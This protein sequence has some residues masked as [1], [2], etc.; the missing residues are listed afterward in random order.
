M[1]IRIS[2]A[3][4]RGTLREGTG[5]M[6]AAGQDF[7]YSFTARFENGT[8]SNPEELIAAAHAGCFSM[9]FSEQLELAGYPS[10]WVKTSAQVTVEKINTG[11]AIT[12][13]HL[14]CAADV[15]GIDNATFQRTAQLA[16]IVCP[17]S[18]AL[19]AVPEIT[20]DAALEPGAAKAA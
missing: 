2:T 13:I 7:P 5:D 11:F 8:G 3:E 12:R 4:W 6:R 17:V 15:P 10:R 20:L 19:A 16:K 18:K 9:A 1:P 14:H